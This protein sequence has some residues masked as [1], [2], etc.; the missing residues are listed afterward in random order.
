MPSYLDGI[1]FKHI[2]GIYKL[3]DKKIEDFKGPCDLISDFDTSLV[4]SQQANN[5]SRPQVWDYYFHEPYLYLFFFAYLYNY[6]Y[7]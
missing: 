6:S 2:I 7:F 1:F 3:K 5:E 4:L